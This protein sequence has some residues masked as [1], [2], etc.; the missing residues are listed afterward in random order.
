MDKEYTYAP[1]VIFAFNR[2][3]HLKKTVSALSKCELAKSSK[4]IVFIDG[5][6]DEEDVPKQKLMLDYLQSVVD[7]LCVEVRVREK[8]VGL[9]INVSSGITDV[10]NEYGRAIILEDDILVSSHFLRYMNESLN[11]YQDRKEVWHISGWNFPLVEDDLPSCFLWRTALGWGWATWADRWNYYERDPQALLDE[12]DEMD[13]QAFNIYGSYN[14]WEQVVNNAT[15][16]IRT[17]AVFWYAAIFKNGGL[18]LNPSRA[19]TTNIGFDGS[20][21][22]GASIEHSLAHDRDF[23]YK[24]DEFPIDLSENRKVVSSIIRFNKLCDDYKK[25]NQNKTN[26]DLKRLVRIS[27][28]YQTHF[29]YLLGKKVAIFGTADISLL[30]FQLLRLRGIS[31]CAFLVSASSQSEYIEGVPI[32]QPYQWHALNPHVVINCIEGNHESVIA[33]ILSDALSSCSIISWRSL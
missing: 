26:I 33:S 11:F 3:A 25:T 28:S 15:G 4:V 1:I 12:F 6:R 10:M 8:N 9:E 20:G 17:W 22:H 5:S 13:I 2:P 32:C 16:K 23:Y 14:F 19:M 18:C 30:V 29:S 24:R 21:T 27:L 7:F 31:V